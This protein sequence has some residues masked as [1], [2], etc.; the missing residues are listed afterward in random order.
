MVFLKQRAEP[1]TVVDS[2]LGIYKIYGDEG[3]QDQVCTSAIVRIC[4]PFWLVD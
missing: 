3:E 2:V 1:N 4:L